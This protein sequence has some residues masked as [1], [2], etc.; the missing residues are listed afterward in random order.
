M[1]LPPLE[2]SGDLPVGVHRATLD[3]VISRFGAGSRQ[4]GAVTGR[5]KRVHDMAKATGKLERS[6]VFGSYITSKLV[7]NDVDIV[8]VMSQ[9]FRVAECDEVTKR[10]FDHEQA[11]REFGASVFWIR[12]SLLLVGS[13]EEFIEHWQ[14]KGDGSRRGIVEVIP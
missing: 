13:M 4:R 10:L 11:D 7:P 9:N 5:L 12:P 3:E 8:L 2:L 14:V 6:V 1:A